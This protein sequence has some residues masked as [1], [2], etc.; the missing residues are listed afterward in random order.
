MLCKYRTFSDLP[1]GSFP[2][3]HYVWGYKAWC[4]YGE[5]WTFSKFAQTRINVSSHSE[6]NERWIHC[7]YP[8]ESFRSLC[9][10]F[11]T[12]SPVCWQSRLKTRY[13]PADRLPGTCSGL[14][15]NAAAR[16]RFDVNLHALTGILHGLIGLGLIC[17]PDFFPTRQEHFPAHQRV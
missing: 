16:Y 13:R 7:R 11:W 9:H 5:Y 15:F 6:C 8:S 1:C 12:A 4:V 10:V 2:A 3:C 14:V 17:L